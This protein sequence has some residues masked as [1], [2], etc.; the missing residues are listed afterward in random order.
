M[1]DRAAQVGQGDTFQSWFNS[2]PLVTKVLVVST[3]VTGAATTFQFL[4]PETLVLDWTF[5]ID[6][7][8]VWRLCTPFIYAGPFSFNFALH[9]LTLYENCRRYESNPFNTGAGGNTADFLW[10]VIISMAVL[11]LVSLVI[12]TWVLSDELLFTILY[13]WSRRDPEIMLNILGFKF[14]ALYLPWVFTGIRL[15]MGGSI[16]V[17]LVGIAV[18]H[19]YYFLVD[20]LPR[21]NGLNI[22]KTPRF[23]VDFVRWASGLTPSGAPSPGYTSYAPP[24]RNAGQPT[25][26]AAPA[27]ANDGTGSAGLRHRGPRDPRDAS[28]PA[29][30]N[31]GTGRVLGGN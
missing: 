31:W 29:T 10:M 16:T 11:L 26:A 18:G 17:P 9:V 14:K 27:G 20:I 19:L 8:E 24:T 7:F 12:P 25:A 28:R 13:V 5:L 30:Y 4:S 2:V 1:A 21:T 22:I 3:L 23:C 15:V 6:R